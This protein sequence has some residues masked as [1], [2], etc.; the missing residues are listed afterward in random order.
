M[1]V[2]V[3]ETYLFYYGGVSIQTAS[4]LLA[5]TVLCLIVLRLTG[6]FEA[7]FELLSAVIGGMFLLQG[8]NIWQTEGR[9]KEGMFFAA[10]G[11]IGLLASAAAISGMA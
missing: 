9:K 2:S 11:M 5:V 8:V 1:V 6:I 7:G 3:K 4:K 10:V